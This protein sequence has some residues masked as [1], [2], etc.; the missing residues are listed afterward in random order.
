MKMNEE[1]NVRKE[2]VKTENNQRRMLNDEELEQVSG[3]TSDASMTAS[4]N[5]SGGVTGD[6]SINQYGLI[7]R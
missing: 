6:A 2:E 7:D 5:V 1:P 4:D 3:G